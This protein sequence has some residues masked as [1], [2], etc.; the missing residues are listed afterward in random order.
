V[1]PF[2]LPP[3]LRRGTSPKVFGFLVPYL[4]SFS[5]NI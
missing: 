4:T 1:F 5:L 3:F 2:P